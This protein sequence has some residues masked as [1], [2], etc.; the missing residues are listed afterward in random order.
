M[1]DKHTRIVH[2]SAPAACLLAVLAAAPAH[3]TNG[4]FEHGY[5]IKSQGIGG[6]GV[7]LPQDGLAAAANP[8]G[9]AFVGNRV[10]V[11]L[12]WFMPKRSADI[13]GNAAPST[14]VTTATASSISL[15]LNSAPS[16]RSVRAW[17][18]ASP[19]TAMAA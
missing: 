12:S 7:A 19:S 18:P 6:G 14:A 9:S 16:G 1:Q 15:F 2:R 8:A 13:V 3:A 10:D 5:G 17:R 11:G 4:Y